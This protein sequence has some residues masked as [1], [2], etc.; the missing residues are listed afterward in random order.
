MRERSGRVRVALV[1]D[2]LNQMG[3]AEKVILSHPHPHLLALG[4]VYHWTTR[5]ASA[6][7]GVRD[8]TVRNR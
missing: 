8:R 3:G 1:H 5:L 7:D 6:W 4:P 2:Y